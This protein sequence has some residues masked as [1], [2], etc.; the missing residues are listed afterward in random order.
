M[1]QYIEFTPEQ[2]QA[3]GEMYQAGW[4]THKLA[5]RYGISPTTVTRRLVAMDIPLR[6]LRANRTA[7]DEV[8]AKA[9]QMR[10]AGQKWRDV[11]KATG[12]KKLT[13]MGAI[14]RRNGGK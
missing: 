10:A 14:R 6:P 3:L 4:S 9:E 8:V 11:E 1:S 2:L 12:V 5:K 13:I 7:T